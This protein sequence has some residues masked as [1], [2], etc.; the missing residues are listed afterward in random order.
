MLPPGQE[1]VDWSNGATVTLTSGSPGP[2]PSNGN[3]GLP[4][5][6]TGPITVTATFAGTGAI[7]QTSLRFY[8]TP[9]QAAAVPEPANLSWLVGGLGVIGIAGFRRLKRAS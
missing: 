7:T 6:F 9:G 5:D 4:A 3:I 2:L 1:V 8:E